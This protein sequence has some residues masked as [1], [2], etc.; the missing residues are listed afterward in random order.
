MTVDGGG[1][2]L[3]RIAL[4]RGLPSLGRQW[5]KPWNEL[6]PLPR[7]H[8]LPRHLRGRLSVGRMPGGSPGNH[9]VHLAIEPMTDRTTGREGTLSMAGPTGSE[10]TEPAEPENPG[11]RDGPQTRTA[12]GYDKP[13]HAPLSHLSQDRC[14]IS[15]S[16]G[17]IN[18]KGPERK[19]DSDP[20][21]AVR[22]P[23]RERAAS[24]T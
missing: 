9:G 17:A 16:Y 22:P 2:G 24:K 5:R 11:D 20:G 1:G 21:E 14:H 6:R 15:A 12:C 8:P 10:R 19:P 4:G 3:L 18:V 7:D 13:Q 23:R